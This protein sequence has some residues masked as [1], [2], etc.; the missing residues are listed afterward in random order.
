M[1]QGLWFHGMENPALA[2]CNTERKCKGRFNSHSA[3]RSVSEQALFPQG[4]RPTRLGFLPPI[5]DMPTAGIIS[6]QVP[7]ELNEDNLL[8]T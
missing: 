3:S 1:I 4:K 5:R 2:L 6:G 7:L 8:L